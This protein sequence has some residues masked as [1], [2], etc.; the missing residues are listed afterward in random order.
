[1]YYKLYKKE[2]FPAEN[3]GRET[4]RKLAAFPENAF[5]QQDIIWK[6]AILEFTQ[7]ETDLTKEPDCDCTLLIL[8]GEAILAYQSQRAARLKELDQD[9]FDG[10][11]FVKCFGKAQGCYLAVQKGNKGFLDVLQLESERQDIKSKMQEGYGTQ[12]QAFYCLDGYGIVIF[13]DR[14]CIIKPGELL[15][16]SC[17]AAE[18]FDLGVMGEGRLIRAQILHDREGEGKGE[19]QELPAKGETPPSQKEEK[20]KGTLEDFKECMKL[21]LT[22]FRGSRFLF[23]YLKQIWYDESLKAGIRKI[24]RF[25]LPVL[26]WFAG[27]AGFGMYGGAYRE[28][29]QVLYML[30]IWTGLVLFL[31]SPLMYFVAV[32]KPVK[33]H[34]KR[35]SEMTEHEKSLRQKEQ[36]E[37]PMADRILKKYKISGRNVYIEDD[38]PKRRKKEHSEP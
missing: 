34:I 13:G 27:I 38:R 26:L 17:K 33:A 20:Q 31:L 12:D 15:V 23:P 3:Q 19:E 10:A 37:N 24:E 16:I 25:Y 18:S 5:E 11:A 6:I 21:S 36:E 7:E 4:I 32:P 29:L 2:N 8:K 14:T 28:P 9:R 22:N 35:L 30:L 1:M